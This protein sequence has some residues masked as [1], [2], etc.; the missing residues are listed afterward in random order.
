[1]LVHVGTYEGPCSTI[2][3]LKQRHPK[4]ASGRPVDARAGI[5]QEQ[6]NGGSESKGSTPAGSIPEGFNWLT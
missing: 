5:L 3:C 6:R 1:M 2:S 4:S